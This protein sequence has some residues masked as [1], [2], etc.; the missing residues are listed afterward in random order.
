MR[1]LYSAGI[2]I[3][4]LAVSI[5]ANKNPKARLMIDG[6]KDVFNYL[7]SRIS[8]NDSVIWIHAASLGEFEQ[9]RPLIERIKKQYPQYKILL[10]FF[11]PSGYEVRKDY[12]YA[13]Y[14][15]YLPFDKL[16]LVK[17]F[18]DL[19]NPKMTFFIKYEFWANY[20]FE[21]KS[22][23]IPVYLISAIFRPS[24]VFFKSY[25]AFF[26]KLLPFYK[27]IFVQNETSFKLLE[28]LGLSNV[29]ISGDTRF[30]RV[31]EIAEESKVLPVVEDFVASSSFTLVA[32]SSWPKDED[33]IID[34]LNTNQQIKTIIAPHEIHKDHIENIISKLKRNYIRYSEITESNKITKKG[35]VDLSKYDVLIIDCIGLLSSVY[36]Y[37]EC[38]YIGGGFGVGIHNILEAAVYNIPVIFG[39]NY[40]KFYEAVKIIEAKGGFAINDKQEYD[41]LMNKLTSDHQFLENSG[42]NAGN[43]VKNN[44]GA[45]DI[46]INKIFETNT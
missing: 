33:I 30:D 35:T 18:L 45:A 6:H 8:S 1:N 27:H 4:S 41:Q 29:S 28:G 11:S 3:Y 17:R 15:C 42:N 9:G 22:R 44:S 5:A 14:I 23:N 12:K 38:A 13:D 19:V 7:K 37:G 31:I 16:S 40:H 10:T 2:E 20:L 36:K 24:Q 25:G 39:P 46:V 26:R 34:Y 32:G 43:Y 21:L